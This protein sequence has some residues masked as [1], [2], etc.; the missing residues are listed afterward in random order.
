MVFSGITFIYFFLPAVLL[1]Y[2]IV[3]KRMKN[4]VLLLASMFFYFFG[5]PKYTALMIG[6]S[7]VSY[8][9]A[10]LIERFRGT[11]WQKPLLTACVSLCIAALL[12]FKYAD[13]IISTVNAVANAQIMPL[14]LALPIG[15]SFYT[16]QAL[17]YA[18][19]VYRGETKAQRN[20]I[21][22]AMYLSLFP[23]LIAG[24]IVRYSVVEKD[25]KSRTH[26]MEGFALGVR[27]FVIGLG[28]KVL[29]ANAIGELTMVYET[30]GE[31][32][33]VFTWLYII[34]YCLQ[35]YFDFSG[36]T[37]M[38]I[39][40]GKMFGF[41]FPENFNYPFISKSVAEFWRRW[42]MTLGT[43][44]RDYV[45]IPMGGNRVKKLRWVLNILIV[46]ALTGLWHG[47][48]WNFVVWGLFFAVFLVVERFAL[49]KF[50][51]KAPKVLRHFYVLIVIAISF[52]IFGAENF[53]DA[54]VR[55]A[56]MFGFGM[57]F[58]NTQTLYNLRS[59]AVVLAIA[60]VGAT[61]LPSTLAKK[62]GE[63]G[64]VVDFLEPAALIFVMVL[65]TAFL[66][67]GSFN[68]FLYFRF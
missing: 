7:L 4:L 66:V 62:L 57:P 15:I 17:S 58:V 19:D 39:G 43:W 3:P 13:F 36:Y 20:F 12:H 68:P 5:E 64:R 6:S 40:L 53:A 61:P 50:L 18:V 26:S 30:A 55:I 24:P 54:G 51:E 49:S 10:L 34:A 33:V 38:A 29:L 16:F 28:K 65:A 21:D 8:C 59:F 67:D 9:F 1:L 35:V 56:G 22:Y 2:F 42:H 27:R 32:T 31:A 14:K 25:I 63:K 45:Y 41:S 52:I 46:W 37:D 11:K 47:A 44:F 23:Q 48:A 60:V